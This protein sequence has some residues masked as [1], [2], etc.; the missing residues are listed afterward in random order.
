MQSVIGDSHP[1]LLRGIALGDQPLQFRGSRELHALKLLQQAH[2]HS[3]CRVGIEE[4]VGSRQRREWLE[5]ALTA[6]PS[7]QAPMLVPAQAENAPFDPGP[8]FLHG[9]TGLKLIDVIDFCLC[10]CP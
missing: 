7:S 3:V 5:P 4:G 1:Y 9:Y 10:S 2:G 8:L 6:A